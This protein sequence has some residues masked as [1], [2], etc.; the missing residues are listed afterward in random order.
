[1]TR[2]TLTDT[3]LKE[4]QRIHNPLCKRLYT[5]KEAAGYLGRSVWGMRDLIWAQIIPVVKQ[6]GSR[7]IY[8]DIIDLDKFIE[9]NKAVYN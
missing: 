7:K 9:K 1:M 6:P 4:T 8:L 5:L 2:K 3:A